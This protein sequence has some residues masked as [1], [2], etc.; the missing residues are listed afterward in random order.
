M[1][2]Q[3]E[4]EGMQYLLM[5]EITDHICDG[6]ALAIEDQFVTNNG[7]R[8]ICKMNCGWKMC[9]KWKD[10][11]PSWESTLKNLKESK[12]I[13]ISEYAV[14]NKLISEP[15]ALSWCVPHTLKKRD[16]KLLVTC[17]Q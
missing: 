3:V 2:P 17:Q 5:N 1:F 7:R 9:I 16:R 12:P 13:K 11:S 4:D 14:T 6:T 15:A 10:G 8:L